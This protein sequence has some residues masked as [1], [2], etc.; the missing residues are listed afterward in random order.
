M[1]HLRYYRAERNRIDN[2]VL[3]MPDLSTGLMPT[4]EEYKNLEERI[5]KQLAEKIAAIDAEVFVAP[6]PP[7]PVTAEKPELNS[8]IAN[9]AASEAA[10]IAEVAIVGEGADAP[11]S[12]TEVQY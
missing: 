9:G 1:V 12:T 10:E 11:A 5:Q 4:A 3:M 8:A 6:T 2:V 7:A